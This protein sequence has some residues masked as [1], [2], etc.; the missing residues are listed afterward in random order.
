MAR[1][2]VKRENIQAAGATIAGQELEHL[3]RV[4]RLT[5]GEVPTSRDIR[6]CTDGWLM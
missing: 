6:A 1:F 4:L 2:F 3:R 5:V